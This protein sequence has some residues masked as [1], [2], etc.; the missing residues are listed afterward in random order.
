MAMNILTLG[1]FGEEFTQKAP[2]LSG[3]VMQ[4]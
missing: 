1:P 2:G 3:I 4:N